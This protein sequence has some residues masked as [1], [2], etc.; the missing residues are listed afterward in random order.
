[1]IHLA[2]LSHRILTKAPKVEVSIL[3]CST[4]THLTDGKD[5]IAQSQSSH[6]TPEMQ[7]INSGFCNK[8]KHISTSYKLAKD[9]KWPNELAVLMPQNPWLLAEWTCHN[10]TNAISVM[11]RC[12][13]IG[14]IFW[15]TGKITDTPGQRLSCVRRASFL[16]PP[17][18]NVFC[19]QDLG[20]LGQM[21]CV[22]M[23]QLASRLNGM[24]SQDG[25]QLNIY[26]AKLNETNGKYIQGRP[27]RIYSSARCLRKIHL[28]AE[29]A[30][31]SLISL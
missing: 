4:N 13:G 20:F 29:S 16:P 27:W 1:M 31:S 11:L 12:D 3:G 26:E 17:I 18:K 8:N 25:Q 19:T 2:M 22:P 10:P 28:Y 9:L 30:D 6:G 5:F 23:I 24:I 14:P 15:N 7:N 21:H